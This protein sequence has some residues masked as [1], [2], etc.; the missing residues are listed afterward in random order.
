MLFFF[1]Y[2]KK[3][4]KKKKRLRTEEKI[5]VKFSDPSQFRDIKPINVTGHGILL[6]KKSQCFSNHS[7]K[8]CATIYQSSW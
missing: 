3:K 5:C 1:F 8:G 2:G 6:S 4:K 7:P